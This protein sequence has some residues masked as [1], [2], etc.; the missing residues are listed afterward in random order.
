MTEWHKSSYSGGSNDC[1][2][3]REGS[4][5]AD[6]RDTQN[7]EAGHLRFDR[8]EWTALVQSVGR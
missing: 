6:V 4:Q 2:E 1:L 8:V 3:A 7:R 5:G